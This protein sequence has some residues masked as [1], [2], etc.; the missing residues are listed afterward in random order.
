MDYSVYEPGKYNTDREVYT[1]PASVTNPPYSNFGYAAPVYDSASKVFVAV[2]PADS[3]ASFKSSQPYTVPKQATSNTIYKSPA[4]Y[5]APKKAT[6]SNISFKSPTPYT[7][8]KKVAPNA[9]YKSY[10]H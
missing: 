10:A 3:H 4:P 6:T 2:A 7:A 5:T 8:P 1:D 9:S